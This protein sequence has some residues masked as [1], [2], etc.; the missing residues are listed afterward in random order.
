MALKDSNPTSPTTICPSAACGAVGACVAPD[1]CLLAAAVHKT[2]L[3]LHLCPACRRSG[4]IRLAAVDGRPAFRC[5]G[6]DHYWTAGHTGAPYAGHEQ[7][8]VVTND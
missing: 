2:T 4:F 3:K 8:W 7:M 1:D 6:C 5:L